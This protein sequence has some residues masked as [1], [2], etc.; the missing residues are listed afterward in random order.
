MTLFSLLLDEETMSKYL[1]LSTPYLFCVVPSRCGRTIRS[2]MRRRWPPRAVVARS[3]RRATSR[4]W[5]RK[6]NRCSSSRETETSKSTTMQSRANVKQTNLSA[7]SVVAH[8]IGMTSDRLFQLQYLS[9]ALMLIR[10]CHHC[11]FCLPQNFIF[12]TPYS[13]FIVKI[14]CVLSSVCVQLSVGVSTI[15][16]CKYEYL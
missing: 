13:I 5:S 7:H 4:A 15:Y 16:P 10:P 11:I 3:R 9:N 2:S 8:A 12:Q 6:R 1:F 14:H